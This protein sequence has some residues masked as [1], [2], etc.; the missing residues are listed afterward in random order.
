MKNIKSHINLVILFL[1]T[2]AFANAQVDR[3]KTPKAGP[4]PQIQLQVPIEF[5]LDNGMT[6]LL[7]ENKKL[8][9]VSYNLTIDNLPSL[10][11]DK[12]GALSILGTM[13][14]N[15]TA[16]ISKDEFNEEVDFLG[17]TINFSS[18]GGFAS[19]LSKYSERLLELMA[20]AAMNPLLVEDEF[21][22]EKEKQIE[23]LKAGEKSV[24][25]VT[26]RVE[27]ALV[28][29]KHHPYGEFITEETL[30]K[31]TLD[32]VRVFY[33][34]LFNPENAYLVIIGDIDPNT[35]QD[36]VKKYFGVWKSKAI[37]ETS[38]PNPNP[39]VQFTQINFVDMPN[40]VQSNIVVSNNVELKMGDKDYHA[41]LISNFI[42]GGGGT[43][44]LFRNLREDKGYTYGSYSSIGAS[45]FG[46][47]KFSATAEV[48]NEVTDSSVI[49]I[50]KEIKKIRTEK[51]APETL[52]TA[53]ASYVGSFV[54]ALERPE[55]IAN[56]ALNIKLNDLPLDYYKNYLTNIN[57]VTQDDVM[58]VANKYFLSDNARIVVV[59]KG[60]DILENLEKTGIPI[61]Y[62]DPYA[63]PVDKP[64][65]TKPIPEGV[66]AQS[67]LDSYLNAIGGKEAAKTV[68]TI[69]AV[70]DVK[71]EGVPFAPTAEIKT[72]APYKESIEMSI[73]GM[74]VIMK[75]KFNGETGY[76]EQ[77]GQRKDLT[78]DELG[79]KKSEYS[80]IPELHYDLSKVSLESMM[81]IEGSDVYKIK[82]SDGKNDSYRYYDTTTG[83]LLRVESTVKSQGQSITSVADFGNYS[84]VKGVLFPYSQTVKAGPQVLNFNYTN[85]KVNEGVS[86]TDFD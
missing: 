57:E 24:A 22:K 38:V 29:G 53:K 70:A 34:K 26:D 7:V 65:F 67:V 56:Y 14:G 21:N 44:Y 75:Q 8:P 40:A 54:R 4:A 50:L 43:G 68:E 80:I 12:A 41:A 2:I 37:I 19:G 31:I 47:S 63:N 1:I 71:I 85:I 82:V 10:E 3:S 81:T 6:V 18:R 84:P 15:G 60:S 13:L 49:E 69:L 32:N 83:L 86:D 78:E 72:K 52:E 77:Q 46:A 61:K 30:N 25:T 74:G 66:T 64:V 20:D 27:N 73:E 42:L 76:M 79:S 5:K 58:R 39:N 55:T 48:R 11:G 28:Y 9:R 17:A 33:E 59:G 62:F 36:Q 51:V 23:G 45:R 16:T 35:I